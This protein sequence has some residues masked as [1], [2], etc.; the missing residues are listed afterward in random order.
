MTKAPTITEAASRSTSLSKFQLGSVATPET[1][2]DVD[3]RKLPAGVVVAQ[4]AGISAL[5]PTAPPSVYSTE[6]DG[7]LKLVAVTAGD[8]SFT[9]T[10]S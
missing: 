6:Q 1:K 3:A 4:R 2:S 9:L 7:A 5:S 8:C 10:T